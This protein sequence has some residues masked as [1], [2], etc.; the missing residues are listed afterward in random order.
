MIFSLSFRRLFESYRLPDAG[1]VGRDC[2]HRIASCFILA[3]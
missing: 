2:R 3:F 1:F